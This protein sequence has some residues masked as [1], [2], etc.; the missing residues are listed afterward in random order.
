MGKWK[1]FFPLMLA[2]MVL[3]MAGCSAKTAVETELGTFTYIR[4]K[5]TNQYDTLSASEGE[6]LLILAFSAGEF[7][8]TQ[9]KAHFAPEDTAKAAQVRVDGKAYPCIAVG[10]Q[11]NPDS[12]SVEYALIFR[13]DAGTNA[14]KANLELKAPGKD[15]INLK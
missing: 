2:L 15:W 11:G 10:Y 8:E 4:S 14:E 7:D 12:S 5:T 3:A 6:T 9:F 13:V 1:R